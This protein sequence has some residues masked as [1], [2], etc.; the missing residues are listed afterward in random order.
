MK[1][2]TYASVIIGGDPEFFVVG[3][4]KE[5]VISADKFF[6][7]KDRKLKTPAGFLFFDGVQAEINFFAG[8]CREYT[9]DNVWLCLKKAKDIIGENHIISALPSVVMSLKDLRNAH[10]EARRFGCNPDWNAYTKE[11]NVCEIDGETH[12]TRYAGG[13]I[14]VGFYKYRDIDTEILKDPNK[15]LEY[16]K[17]MDIIVGIPTAMLD[18][19][20][21]SKRRR[22]FYGKAGCFR[23]TEYGLE[24]RTP[25]NFWL[26][27]PALMSFTNGLVKLAHSVYVSKA[28][29]D[30]FDRVSEEEVRAAIDGGSFNKIVKI[31]NKIRD[32]LIFHGNGNKMDKD[33]TIT[34]T[35]G[36]GR[37]YV[38]E[39]VANYGMLNFFGGYE[40][41]E[42]NW[43]LTENL[44]IH[45]M[46]ALGWNK[47]FDEKMKDKYI[48]EAFFAYEEKFRINGDF[49]RMSF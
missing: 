29:D 6:P 26:L 11:M 41:V 16:I 45:G 1:Q 19:S 8:S 25:S 23:P 46:T 31:Y 12:R 18:Q 33:Y 42:N 9:Q 49:Q 4:E 28:A 22:R 10:P 47:T 20:F 34:T 5:E 24:Y 44:E 35:Y 48:K 21:E 37:T 40:N 2:V 30:Y 17:L 43:K 15:H 39:F 7:S 38:F 27:S 13:H 14:H 32:L 36:I 3:R